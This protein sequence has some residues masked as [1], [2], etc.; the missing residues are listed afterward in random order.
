[1]DFALITLVNALSYG[2]VVFLI[3]SGL[4]LVYGLMGVMNFSHS[5]FYMAG[6]YLAFSV[7]Q[8]LG[9]FAAL[10]LVPVLVGI[11]GWL[12]ERTLLQ[13][14]YKAGHKA[15]ML[16]TFGF[17]LVMV[18]VV[19]LIWGSGPVPYRIPPML[20]TALFV[21][22]VHQISAYRVVSMGITLAVLL[23]LL[24][25]LSRTSLGL[26]LKAAA[27]HPVALA[28]LGHNVPLLFRWVFAVGCA[29][30]GLAGVLMGNVYVT[31]PGMALH[32]GATSF[33][34]VV[35][36]GLGSLL[37]AF[38]ASLAVGLLQTIAASWEPTSAYAALIPYG[39]LMAVMLLRPRGILGIDGAAR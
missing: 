31:E 30:A 19:Q 16:V 3:S 11:L 6:A 36:G 26:M 23:A 24:L 18:E 35:M 37:G 12:F 9:F 29:L 5:G 39:L 33:A 27:T 13:S 15:E 32:M 25:V 22:G 34:V 1:M 4:T 2:L 7:S 38:Y 21:F 10:L 20:D 8:W 28:A 14:V 17:S